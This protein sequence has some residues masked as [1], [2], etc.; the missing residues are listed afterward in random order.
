MII[1]HKF[2]LLNVLIQKFYLE[3]VDEI[4]IIQ[5]IIYLYF[6]N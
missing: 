3:V 6:N 5:K 1:L 4:K 2:S